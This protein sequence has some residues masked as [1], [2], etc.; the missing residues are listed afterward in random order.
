MPPSL[1]GEL[2]ARAALAGQ[3][4]QPPAGAAPREGLHALRR[5]ST[6][7]DPADAPLLSIG[8]I[9]PA[10]AALSRPLYEPAANL[11]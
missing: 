7:P 4:L 11:R 1:R 5:R 2:H 3:E 10:R 9:R 6:Y 8:A